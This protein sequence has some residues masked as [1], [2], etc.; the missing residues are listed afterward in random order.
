MDQ[1]IALYIL[2]GLLCA[3]GVVRLLLIFTTKA[4]AKAKK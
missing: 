2:G 4:K 3:I 1:K